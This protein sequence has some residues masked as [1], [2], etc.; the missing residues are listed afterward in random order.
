[1]SEPRSNDLR[2]RP[3]QALS[4]IEVCLAI[5]ILSLILISLSSVFTQGYRFL[6]KTRMSNMACF[7]AQEKMEDFL[8]NSTIDQSRGNYIGT[9]D[10]PYQDF[11]GTVNVIYPASG[12][13]NNSTVEG[14]MALVNVTIFWQG[15][16]GQEQNYSLS[17]LVTN[18]TH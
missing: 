5:V 18:L 6:R 4:L 3:S 15:Q 11:R 14:Y 16:S 13:G 1:M 7:L 8:H 9:L 2:H 12:Y 10:P 17:S